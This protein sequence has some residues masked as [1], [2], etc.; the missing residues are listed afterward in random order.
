MAVTSDLRTYPLGSTRGIPHS[1]D[2]IASRASIVAI[3]CRTGSK[4]NRRSGPPVPLTR[5]RRRGTSVLC[6]KYTLSSVTAFFDTDCPGPRCHNEFLSPSNLRLVVRVSLAAETHLK[7]ASRI[8]CA[9]GGFRGH[10][11]VEGR[12][13]G[14]Y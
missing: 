10:W 3:R 8:S 14:D 6:S 12:T 13:F 11:A 2:G 9:N 4:H 5:T 1:R 7:F